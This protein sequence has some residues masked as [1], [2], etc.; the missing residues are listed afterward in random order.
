MFWLNFLL[1][2]SILFTIAVKIALLFEIV[3]DVAQ[4]EPAKLPVDHLGRPAAA[5]GPGAGFDVVDH[6]GY[7]FVLDVDVNH[8]PLIIP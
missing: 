3:L 5:Q 7:L 1:L 2:L 6:V 8:F 4:G